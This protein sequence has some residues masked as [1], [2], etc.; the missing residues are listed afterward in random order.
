MFCEERTYDHSASVV[1]VAAMVELTHCGVDDWVAGFT[2]GPGFEMILVIFPFYVGVFW[3]ER[4][5]H[6]EIVS[7]ALLYRRERTRHMASEP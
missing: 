1:H 4:F 2:F 6:A 7:L 3:F 5:V